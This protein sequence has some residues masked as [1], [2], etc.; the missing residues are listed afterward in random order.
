MW[1]AISLTFIIL[2]DLCH[3]SKSAADKNGPKT[4]RLL[5]EPAMSMSLTAQ[6]AGAAV[7]SGGLA[8]CEFIK[9]KGFQDAQAGKAP[10]VLGC[11][12]C[13]CQIVYDK[14]YT[15]SAQEAGQ[16]DGLHGIPSRA[17]TFFRFGHEESYNKGYT[18][19][20]NRRTAQNTHGYQTIE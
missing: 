5:M 7:C 9:S 12:S 8:A 17:A 19:G 20:V 14:A 16:S 11:S 3:L 2:C 4:R 18:D 13:C 15:S 10:L 6:V 1:K